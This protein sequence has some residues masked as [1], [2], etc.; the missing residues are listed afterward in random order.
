[1]AKNKICNNCNTLLNGAFCSICGQKD[2]QLLKFKELIKEFFDHILDLDFRVL[3]TLKYLAIKPGFLTREYWEGKRVR[4]LPPF[5]LYLLASFIYFITYSLLAQSDIDNEV[6][7]Q[8]IVEQNMNFEDRF[9]SSTEDVVSLVD[10]YEKEIELFFFLPIIALLLLFFNRKIN[11]L[12]FSHHFIASLHLSSTLFFIDTF[13]LVLSLLFPAYNTSL[14]NFF[15]FC[16]V[17]YLILTFKNL[18]EHSIIKS[19]F[20]A[21]L[22]MSTFFIIVGIFI[23]FGIFFIGYM[24]K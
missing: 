17:V 22:L 2:I 11:H 10:K 13:I 23:M 18:Y 21:I 24:V 7:E 4:Y 14:E 15:M 19:V 5:K 9:A 6:S 20:N 16:S 3:T 12:Y 1:M 8:N